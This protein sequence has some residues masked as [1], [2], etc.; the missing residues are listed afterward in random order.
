M[1]F[2]TSPY[3]VVRFIIGILVVQ[4]AD[5]AEPEGTLELGRL[6]PVPNKAKP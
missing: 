2:L 5:A 1:L 6:K 4:A 3:N